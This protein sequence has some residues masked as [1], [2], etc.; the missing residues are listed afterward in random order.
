MNPFRIEGPATLSF[1]GGRTSARMLHGVVDAYDGELPED[2]R[3][4]FAN[5]GKEREE[6]LRFV[7]ECGSRWGVPIH[8]LEYRDH[9]K[10]TDLKERFAKVGYNSASRNSEPFDMLIERK[11]ALPNGRDR[12]CTEFLKVRVIFDYAKSV[13]FGDPGDFTEIIGLRADEKRRVDRM[14]KDARNGARR[15]ALPLSTAGVRAE[16]IFQFWADQPFDLELPRGT[17]NCDQCPM[18]GFAQR[19]AR[20]QRD[21]ASAEW[22]ARQE[23]ERGHRFSTRTSFI[24]LLGVAASSPRMHLL[25]DVDTECGNGCPA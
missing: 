25:D 19:L 11:Q 4:C 7:H 15:I 1:S 23:M 12:W 6:T 14:L 20:I 10:R 2:I 24:E 9:R 13:G 21:P 16:D 17:G 22:W 18:L 8:W 3:V 5:T